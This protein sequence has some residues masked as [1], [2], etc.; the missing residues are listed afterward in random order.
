MFKIYLITFDPYKT[1]AIGMHGIISTSIY[2][3]NWWHYIGSAYL[4]KSSWTLITIQNEI[5]RK[6]GYNQNFLIIEV[7]PKN[8]GGWLPQDAWSWINQNR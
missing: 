7:D 3:S 6:W 5:T 2:V 4:I 8:Y 1:D